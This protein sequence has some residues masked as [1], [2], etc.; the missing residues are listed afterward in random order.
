MFWAFAVI[1]SFFIGGS[2]VFDMTSEYLQDPVIRKTSIYEGKNVAPLPA[3][4]ICP[5]ESFSADLT[6]FRR[7]VYSQVEN[8]CSKLWVIFKSRPY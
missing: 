2:I 5:S 4:T 7:W 6:A 1:T 3:I 8:W